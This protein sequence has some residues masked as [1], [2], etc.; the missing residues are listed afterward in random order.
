M[1]TR[2]VRWANSTC[3]R[4]SCRWSRSSWIRKRPRTKS[5]KNHPW[6]PPSR[7][8]PVPTTSTPTRSTGTTSC[9]S[10]SWRASSLTISR[11]QSSGTN[12]SAVTCSSS[13]SN[14]LKVTIVSVDIAPFKNYC[15]IARLELVQFKLTKDF[16]IVNA[17]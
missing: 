17:S 8:T 12:P 5:P 2:P 14:D 13:K 6:S 3:R 7:R 15:I 9:T 1:P 16:P 10:P 11:K 4:T